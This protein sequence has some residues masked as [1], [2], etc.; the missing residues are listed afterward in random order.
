[1]R[2]PFHV[3][4]ASGGNVLLRLDRYRLRFGDKAA[5]RDPGL[6]AH[7][8]ATRLR[9]VRLN[10]ALYDGFGGN[11]I[12][13]LVSDQSTVGVHRILRLRHHGKLLYPDFSSLRISSGIWEHS[14]SA[15]AALVLVLIA[16][17]DDEISSKPGSDMISVYFLMTNISKRKEH[18][19]DAGGLV[20]FMSGYLPGTAGI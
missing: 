19:V 20:I 2:I 5:K 1:M 3:R 12:L 6:F 13:L 10:L 15:P 16:V 14:V 8:G 4:L 18:R 9:F 17:A 7:S 11:R